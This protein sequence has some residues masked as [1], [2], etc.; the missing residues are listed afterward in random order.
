[1]SSN[2]MKDARLS[3]K[4]GEAAKIK[5][6]SNGNNGSENIESQYCNG[7]NIMKAIISQQ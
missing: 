2:E 7:E 1:M 4:S 6:K 3:R 5:A